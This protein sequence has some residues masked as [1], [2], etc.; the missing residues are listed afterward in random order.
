VEVIVKVQRWCRG[1]E[2]HQVEC[3]EVQRRCRGAAEVLQM[4]RGAEVQK[5]RGAEVQ[6]CRGGAEVQ[7]CKGAGAGADEVQTKCRRG[8][9]VMQ[10][11]CRRGAEVQMRCRGCAEV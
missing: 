7:R 2:V 11:M 4:F 8:V 10:T 6:K 3:A 5:C 1:A 9:D